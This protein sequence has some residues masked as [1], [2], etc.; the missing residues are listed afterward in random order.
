MNGL[1]VSLRN[2][3]S[4]ILIF[5]TLQS[6]VTPRDRSI[7]KWERY[8]MNTQEE[9]KLK[10][11][12]RVNS[13]REINI[14]ILKNM[15]IAGRIDVSSDT[16][17]LINVKSEILSVLKPI[18][19]LKQMKKLMKF[20]LIITVLFSSLGCMSTRNTM[21][22]EKKQQDWKLVKTDKNEEP[23]WIIYT[24]KI[25]STSF[26]AYKIE[27]DIKSS[28]KSCISSFK[29]DIH[30]LAAGSQNKKYP[31]YQIVDESKD[32]IL[33][34]VIHKEPFPLKNTEM[35]VRYIFFSNEDGSTGVKWKED[36]EANPIQPSKKL[37]RVESFRG[38]WHFSPISDNH[39][40]GIN[41]VHFD[42][43]KMPLW[44]VKPMVFKFLKKGLKDIRD[45][46]SK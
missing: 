4:M 23:S 1:V 36:W 16:Y 9:E 6:C 30:D 29:Q 14:P 19:D 26:L 11:Q 21:S 25:A 41:S 44:L 7:K 43:K 37:S 8:E 31:T 20:Y 32:S 12:N 39:T 33:T 2:F 5:F 40:A 34:Y 46:T 22:L 45:K 18:K 3:I 42:P 10:Q 15:R 38:S 27:G 17:K 13:S 24:R 28:S 35:S